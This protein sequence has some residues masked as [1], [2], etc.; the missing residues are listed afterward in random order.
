M[1]VSYPWYLLFL[2]GK[3][4]NDDGRIVN[5]TIKVTAFHIHGNDNGILKMNHL[6]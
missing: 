3:R 6:I 5:Y 2:K 1:C 4:G